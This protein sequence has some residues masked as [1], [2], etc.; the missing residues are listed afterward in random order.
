MTN[1]TKQHTPIWTLEPGRTIC[2]DGVPLAYLA[3]VGDD[4]KGYALAPWGADELAH[5]IVDSLARVAELEAA[6]MLAED[7]LK[8]CAEGDAE[9]AGPD[10]WNEDGDGY[11]ALAAARAALAGGGK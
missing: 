7:A 1:T 9:D 8:D 6:L 11:A 10:F 4:S 2:A 3:R 5:R